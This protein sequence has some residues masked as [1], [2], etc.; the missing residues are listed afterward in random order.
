MNRN[1]RLKRQ[2]P[3]VILI[4][5]L[6]GMS[7]PLVA[8]NEPEQTV[9]VTGSYIPQ[10]TDQGALP[11]AIIT[12]EQIKRTGANTV[13]QLLQSLAP[14]TQGNSNTVVASVAGVNS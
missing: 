5:A 6:V 12:E 14:A 1:P 2:L 11:V 7:L 10:P 4:S 9:V 8:Q 13:E 3:R